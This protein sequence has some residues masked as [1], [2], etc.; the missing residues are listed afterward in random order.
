MHIIIRQYQVVTGRMEEVVEAIRSDFIP[1]LQAIPG[2]VAYDLIVTGDQLA[3]VSTFESAEGAAASTQLAT[4]F[5][6][7]RPQ[8]GTAIA[9]RTVTEGEV[10]LHLAADPS[11]GAAYS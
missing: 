6:Q 2:F 4:T 9:S 3:S 10:R 1:R 5:V 7:E 8:L 11:L